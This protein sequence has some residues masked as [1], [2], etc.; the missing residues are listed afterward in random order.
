MRRP[1]GLFGKLTWF[2]RGEGWIATGEVAKARRAE[3]WGDVGA[4]VAPMAFELVSAGG[5][6][7]HPSAHNVSIVFGIVKVTVQLP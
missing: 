1:V 3:K 7:F 4:A 2:G 6:H 5:P